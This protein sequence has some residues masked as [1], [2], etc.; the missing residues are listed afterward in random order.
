MIV[1]LNLII[2]PSKGDKI[3]TI[4]SGNVIPIACD[5]NL[6]SNL[7][8]VRNDEGYAIRVIGTKRFLFVDPA[9]RDLV[10][11]DQGY[12]RGEGAEVFEIWHKKV[13]I[14]GD[15]CQAKAIAKRYVDYK[16]DTFRTIK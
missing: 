7:E 13:S 8:L 11:F 9:N 4:E 3:G 6:P 10:V 5:Y 12:Y 1:F 16:N 14:Y 2:R 15:S